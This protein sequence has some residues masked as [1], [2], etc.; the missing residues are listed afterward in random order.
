MAF[1][2][3]DN[4]F[5]SSDRIDHIFVSPGTTVLDARYILTEQSDHPAY[6]IEIQI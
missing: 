1:W 5:N 6:W 4:L 3:D 2:L